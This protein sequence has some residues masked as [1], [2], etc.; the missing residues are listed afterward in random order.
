MVAKNRNFRGCWTCRA[1]K[2]KCDLQQPFCQRCMRASLNCGGY[3]ISLGWCD[4]LTIS[5]ENS[6]LVSIPCPRSE[7]ETR[8]M[9][10]LNRRSIDFAKFPDNQKIETYQEMND[11]LE[12]LDDEV[13]NGNFSAQVGPFSVFL[14]SAASGKSLSEK[15]TL[16]RRRSASP[17]G[18]QQK[19]IPKRKDSWIDNE[20]LAS[21]KLTTLAIKGP[22]YK[23]NEQNMLHILYPK[24]FA[25][26]DSD[27]WLPGIRV[28]DAFFGIST[29]TGDIQI[30][31]LFSN[32][33]LLLKNLPLSFVRAPV[34][35]NYW[36]TLVTPYVFHTIFEFVCLSLESWDSISRKPTEESSLKEVKNNLKVILIYLVTSLSAF[37]KSDKSVKTSAF[38]KHS[39]HMDESL[40]ESIHLRKLSI[41]L[42]N[43]HL[44]EYDNHMS[45]STYEYDTLLL[46]CIVL[47]VEIDNCFGVFENFELL[48]A[49]GEFILERKFLPTEKLLHTAQYL[50]ILFQIMDLMFKSTHLSSF[51]DTSRDSSYPDIDDY[52]ATINAKKGDN[53]LCEKN[54]SVLQPGRTHND[55]HDLQNP[56]SRF[57]VTVDFNDRSIPLIRK[58]LQITTQAMQQRK[59]EPLFE[60]TTS[61]SPSFDKE[62]IFLMYGIPSSLLFLLHA[63]ISLAKFTN[64]KSQHL[65]RDPMPSA[66]LEELVTNWDVCSFWRLRIGVSSSPFLLEFHRGLYHYS[67]AFKNA[68]LVYF[69]KFV[70]RSPPS[71]YQELVHAVTFHLGEVLQINKL[72]PGHASFM[73]SFWPV[74]ICGAD[75]LNAAGQKLLMTLWSGR[76]FSHFNHW[77]AKQLVYELWQRGRH[78]ELLSWLEL[79]EEWELILC[80]I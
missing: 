11:F 12:H 30:T 60:P 51:N 77:R 5:P 78:H 18:E 80:L 14:R 79:V 58:P 68:L 75:L 32:F 21:A 73:P 33:L 41:N 65:P 59:V 1:R 43:Y 8:N 48:F 76:E 19:H 52:A 42:L 55:P 31:K 15:S 49:I 4:P 6:S 47:Q 13:T 9:N 7:V 71:S 38:E 28:A 27:E 66:R 16:K 56:D 53:T 57:R 26:V 40:K 45:D 2:V 17:V 72:L 29:N 34:D 46:L 35:H 69:Q 64:A 36:Q 44:D 37:E 50:V 63:T 62:A 3:D 24:F 25:N 22:H 23:L 54:F 10:L 39:A 70:K 20:L 61:M 67:L 74:L